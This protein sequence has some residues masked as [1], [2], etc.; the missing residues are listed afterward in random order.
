MRV[1]FERFVFFRVH[2]LL[3]IIVHLVI[4]LIAAAAA[5]ATSTL[6]HSVGSLSFDDN[7]E[8]HFG[9]DPNGNSD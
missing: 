9:C 5:A 1:P 7:D 6:I 8:N 4:I 3:L 2:V